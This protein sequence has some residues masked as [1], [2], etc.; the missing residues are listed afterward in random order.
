MTYFYFYKV[1]NNTY[2]GDGLGRLLISQEEIQD[3]AD[4]EFQKMVDKEFEE[5]DF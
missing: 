1:E 5:E 3:R 4:R 2:F